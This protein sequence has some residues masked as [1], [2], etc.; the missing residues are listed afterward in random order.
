MITKIKELE[1]KEIFALSRRGP[2]VYDVPLSIVGNSIISSVFLQEKDDS[3]TLSVAYY[4]RT[5][6]ELKNERLIGD[7]GPIELFLQSYKKTFTSFHDK[8]LLRE[9]GRAHV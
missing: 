9:I 5:T 1:S 2:G 4:D 7:H 6:T 8:P 3:T